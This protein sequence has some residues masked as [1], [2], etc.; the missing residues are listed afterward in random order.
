MHFGS[1]FLCTV[2]IPITTDYEIQP[3]Y[4]PK[5]ADEY[6]SWYLYKSDYKTRP[7]SINHQKVRNGNI[8]RHNTS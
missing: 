4:T 2:T 7:Y 5:Y 3:S 8:W 6:T 1:G